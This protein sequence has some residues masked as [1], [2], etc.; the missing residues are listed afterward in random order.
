[1]NETQDSKSDALNP[2]ND[3]SDSA[4]NDTSQDAPAPEGEEAAVDPAAALQAEVDELKDKL[5]RTFAEM[6]NTR[7]RAEREVRESQVYAVEKFAR[8]L[9]SVSDNFARALENVNEDALAEMSDKGR[10]LFTGVEMT[11][12]EL[13]S[14]FARHG[15]KPV[16]AQPGDAF[17]PNLHQAVSSI[18]SEQ[19]KGSIAVCFAPGWT[20][21]DR[22]LRAAM[23]AVSA[24]PAN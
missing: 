2:E 5:L 12:K 18:P 21:G 19:A 17:D 7:K 3:V 8:D 23:V 1:M 9:L 6:E 11:Q 10:S 24:G 14:V 4:D 20:I 15:V 16:N 22:V 13:I